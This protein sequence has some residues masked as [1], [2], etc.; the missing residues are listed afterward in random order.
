V[1]CVCAWCRKEIAPDANGDGL[2]SH[3]ICLACADQVFSSEPVPL[4]AIID[5][6]PMPVLVVDGDV[7][8]SLL[9][10]KAQ[11][12]LGTTPPQAEHRR[13]GELFDCVYA[14]HPEGC[15]RTIHCA[16]CA[17]RNAVTATHETGEPQVFVPATLKRGDPDDPESVLLTITTIKRDGLILVKLDRVE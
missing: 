12:T 1:K 11:E 14:Q 13:G 2:V 15:G 5:R 8:V 17:L 3:G 10:R 9:N 6:L 7:T 4:Q 16:S